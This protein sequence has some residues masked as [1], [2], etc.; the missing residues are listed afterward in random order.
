M[1]LPDATG[2]LQPLAQH[3]ALS[4]SLEVEEAAGILALAKSAAKGSGG[5]DFR[6]AMARLKNPT[7]G[8]DDGGGGVD[9]SLDSLLAR[10]RAREGRT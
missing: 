4:T 7:V 6:E 1:S 9:E 2:P 3:L 10:A 8:P 5:T